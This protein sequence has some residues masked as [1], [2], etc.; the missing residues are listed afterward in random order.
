MNL[1]MHPVDL[2]LVEILFLGSERRIDWARRMTKGSARND[3][4]QVP[5]KHPAMPP[6]AFLE[7][8]RIVSEVWFSTSVW[9]GR[10]SPW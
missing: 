6:G 1:T 7:P 3:R 10:L 2:A 9:R 5:E 4:V 8:I